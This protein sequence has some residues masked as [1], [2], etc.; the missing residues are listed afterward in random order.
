M[1]NVE[2]IKALQATNGRI[3]KEEILIKAWKSGNR[4]FFYGLKLCYDPFT[5]FGVADKTV[6][7]KTENVKAKSKPNW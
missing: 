6:S 5:T 1:N 4:E 7:V 2:I 3:E